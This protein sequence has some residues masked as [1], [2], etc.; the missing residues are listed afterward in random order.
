VAR[1]IAANNPAERR[2]G[3][4]RAQLKA[5]A[6]RQAMTNIPTRTGGRSAAQEEVAP[7]L[8]L[9]GVA[10]SRRRVVLTRDQ[11][12]AYIRADLVRLLIVAAVL[13][14]VLIAIAVALR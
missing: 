2:S 14:A 7:S 9:S 8:D 5:L 3:V 12:Y 1:K 6:A 4:N 11:E 13:F 10:L